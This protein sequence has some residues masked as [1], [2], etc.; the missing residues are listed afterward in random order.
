MAG[1]G[2]GAGSFP[3]LHNST[4]F[5][6]QIQLIMILFMPKAAILLL[7]LLSLLVD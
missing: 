4:L 5:R 6:S 1:I 3:S 7:S 2:A